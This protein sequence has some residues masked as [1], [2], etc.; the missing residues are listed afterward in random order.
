[1]NKVSC[2]ILI[3]SLIL[4]FFISGGLFAAEESGLTAGVA[5]FSYEDKPES[6]IAHGISVMFFEAMKNVSIHKTDR[7]ELTA[8]LL[9]I[10]HDELL[11]AERE[12]E[13]TVY[14]KRRSSF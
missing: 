8:H 9:K 1:M 13:K 12:L 4:F 10:K 14:G 7:D 11:S 6:S 2:H 5:G 3:F